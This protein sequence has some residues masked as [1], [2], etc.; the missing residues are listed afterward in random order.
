MTPAEWQTAQDPSAMIQWLAEQGYHNELWDFT[1]ACCRRVWDQLPGEAFRGVVEHFERVGVHDIDDAIAD[2]MLALEKLERRYE[3]AS[4]DTERARLNRKI[5]FGRMVT[6]FDYQDG[7]AAA[8]AVSEDIV[9]W[10]NDAE[11]E[12]RE[13][14]SQLRALVP[15]PSQP[16]DEE[17]E[18]DE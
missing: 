17:D 9:D 4:D 2:A 15:D 10:S 8:D 6:S 13:Q 5:G 1:V 7:A 12:R 16:A 18:E 3:K 11:T 14:S